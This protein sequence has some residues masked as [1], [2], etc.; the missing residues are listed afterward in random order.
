MNLKTEYIL[1]R[2]CSLIYCL[3]FV[4]FFL[5]WSGQMASGPCL[6]IIIIVF[7]VNF[8]YLLFLVF[9]F[10]S[11]VKYVLKKNV[12]EGI[13]NHFYR[14]ISISFMLSYN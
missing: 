7:V 13:I 10:N 8:L 14:Q 5:I 11:T 4:V 1:K 12:S 6:Y 9:R 3:Y 2:S